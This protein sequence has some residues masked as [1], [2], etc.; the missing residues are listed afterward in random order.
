MTANAMKGDREACLKA[1]MN[2]HVAKPIDVNQLLNAL[3]RFIKP[4]NHHQSHVFQAERQ[5]SIDNCEKILPP[6]PGVDIQSALNRLGGNTRLFKK[7]LI[8]FKNEYTSAVK[9]IREQLEKGDLNQAGRLAHTLKGLAGNIGARELFESA[10]ALDLSIRHGEKDRYAR[11]LK[12]LEVSLTTVLNSAVRLEKSHHQQQQSPEQTD[13]RKPLPGDTCGFDAPMDGEILTPL[14]EHLNELLKKNNMNAAK[15]LT[16][17]Q[18]HLRGTLFQSNMREIEDAINNLDFE[19]ALLYLE[20][21]V[22]RLK[23]TV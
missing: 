9:E 22:Q 20:N 18:E 2:D 3:A 10:N 16:L 12:D 8:D 21:I 15:Q 23:K 13:E 5:Q 7:L 6:L 17:V 19:R 14:L 4:G 1:G 11:L